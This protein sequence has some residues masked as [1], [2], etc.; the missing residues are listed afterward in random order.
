M[1]LLK[2][3]SSPSWER[4][5]NGSCLPRLRLLN[6][7]NPHAWLASGGRHRMRRRRGQ[8]IYGI[9][10]CS[11]HQKDGSR[12]DAGRREWASDACTSTSRC[13]VG[14]KE[15]QACKQM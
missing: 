9:A 13:C 12:H 6:A 4:A 5:G 1:A 8:Y 3:I 14:P 11:A 15:R 7:L 2:V 10:L